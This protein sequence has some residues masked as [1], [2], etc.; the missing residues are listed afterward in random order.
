MQVEVLHGLLCRKAIC[1]E[2]VEG[3]RPKNSLVMLGELLGRAKQGVADALRAAE[4]ALVMLSRSNQRMCKGNAS[5]WNRVL[6]RTA[7]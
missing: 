7:I 5:N 6:S 1:N 2:Q 4:Q 3:L